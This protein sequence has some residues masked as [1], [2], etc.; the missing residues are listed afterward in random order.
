MDY[1][2]LATGITRDYAERL[3]DAEVGRAKDTVIQRQAEVIE[4]LQQMVA[5]QAELIA[6]LRKGQP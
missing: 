6:L 2:A 5:N 4:T 3:V 1:F